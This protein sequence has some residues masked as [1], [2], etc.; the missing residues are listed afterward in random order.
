MSLSKKM[1]SFLPRSILLSTLLMPAL[2]SAQDYKVVSTLPAPAGGVAQALRV[3][4]EARRLYATRSGGVDVYNIDTGAVAGT[5][6]IEGNVGGIELAPEI[7]R[8]Y[9]SATDGGSVVIFDLDTLATVK[10]VPSGGQE[11]RELEYDASNARIYVSNAGDGRLVAIDAETGA[12]KGGV[13]LGGRLR[14]ASVDG[15]GKLFVVDEA[16][17]VLHVVDTATLSARGSI[18]VWPGKAPAALVNDTRERRLY[19][20]TGNGRMII[21]DPDQGQLLAN[22]TTKGSGAA[23]IAVQYGPARL[24]R[25]FMPNVDGTL[26]VVRNDKLTPSLETSVPAISGG[27]AVAFDDKSGRLFV[28]GNDGIRVIAK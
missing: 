27:T 14:D 10:S 24:A 5:I 1:K 26:D 19:V 17:D 6:A 20:S 9:A 12:S 11:P 2:A 18:P 21:I 28:A 7:R 4:T 23:G 15:R 8:G 22:V 3:D 13:A 25:L 16:R